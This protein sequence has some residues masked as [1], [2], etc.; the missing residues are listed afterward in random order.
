MM[1]LKLCKVSSTF[2]LFCICRYL[3]KDVTCQSDPHVTMSNNSVVNNGLSDFNQWYAGYHGYV[4]ICVCVGGIITN[5]FNVTVLTRR[6]MRTPVNQILSGTQLL[7][8]SIDI[9]YCFIINII[10]KSR[11]TLTKHLVSNPSNKEQRTASWKDP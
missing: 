6:N 8:Y 10:S 5:M 1:Y 11:K 9:A 7:Y 2:I 3:E 4:S